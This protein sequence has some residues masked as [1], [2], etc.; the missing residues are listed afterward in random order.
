MKDETIKYLDKSDGGGVDFTNDIKYWL[1]ENWDPNKTD[2]DLLDDLISELGLDRS[3]YENVIV[4]QGSEV[5]G[6]V[7]G[8]EENQNEQ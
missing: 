7:R 3:W 1:Q 5:I 8:M 4:E 6:I 2:D